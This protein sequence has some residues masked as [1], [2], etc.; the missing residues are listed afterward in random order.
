MTVEE[1]IR[2]TGGILI[3]GQRNIDVNSFCIDSRKIV[4]GD[5]F[6]PFIGENADAHD[7]IQNT[8]NNGAIGC[9]TSRKLENIPDGKIVIKVEDTQK[10][11]QDMG[12]FNREKYNVSVVAITGS[13]GKTSTKDV[14]AS[15][16]SQKF[17]VLKTKGNHNG[18]IGLPYTLLHLNKE[19]QVVVLE[20]GMNEL[21]E[22]SRLTNIAKPNFA[23]FTNIGY[24]HIGNLGSQENILKAKMEILEG[25]NPKGTVILNGD[26]KLLY[27]QKGK[28][29]HKTIFCGT[30]SNCDVIAQ[31]IVVDEHEGTSFEIVYNNKN[32]FINTK[33]LGAHYV[34]AV[35]LAFAIG[36]EFGIEIND[37]INGIK[38]VMPDKMR[39]NVINIRDVKI[40]DDTYNASPESMKA[41]FLVLKA[42]RGKR[43]VAILADMLEMGAF[44][45][46]GHRDVGEAVAQSNI[47]LLITVGDEAKHIA[48]GAIDAGMD[49]TRVVSYDDNEKLKRDIESFILPQDVILV[50]GSRGMKMDAIVKTISEVL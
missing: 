48:K 46:S 17:K 15:V 27:S 20:M 31:N 43:R 6:I 47:D 26:D 16:L 8:F 30:G 3:S 13:V 28:L 11:L 50:K 9:L 41:A 39:I 29:T 42:I 21:G 7:Y 5:F 4:K 45:E 35:S 25:L 12:R 23:V 49:S 22:I 2:A 33:L 32:Y 1:I 36:H 40:I 19:H 10:A 44:S 24:S 37:I 18:A 34:Y 14:I 38:Q